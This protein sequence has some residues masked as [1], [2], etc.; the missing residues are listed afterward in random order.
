MFVPEFLLIL[1]LTIFMQ[2]YVFEFLTL[3]YFRNGHNIPTISE[4]IIKAPEGQGCPRCG[5]FVY[6][7]DQVFS[8]GLKTF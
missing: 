1:I 8:K 4:K 6:H 2:H 5:G 7:A 3:F